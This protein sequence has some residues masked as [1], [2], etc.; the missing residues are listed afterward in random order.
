MKY[1]D[2]SMRRITVSRQI[3]DHLATRYEAEGWWTSETLGDLVAVGL[4]DS[5]DVGFFVHSAVRPYTGTFRD[6]ERVARRLAGGLRRRGVG[7][8][9][10][11]DARCPAACGE[12]REGRR[13]GA[14]DEE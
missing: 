6:V 11:R 1:S 10:N 7:P 14:G 5:P 4:A 9:R 3:P 2:D 12:N 8:V 13:D